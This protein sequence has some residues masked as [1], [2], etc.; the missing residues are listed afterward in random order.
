MKDQKLLQIQS[1]TKI[2]NMQEFSLTVWSNIGRERAGQVARRIYACCCLDAFLS[3]IWVCNLKTTNNAA[4]PLRPYQRR[5]I[6]IM[7]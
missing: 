4:L 2:G 1:R 5:V 6:S 7:Y 3:F